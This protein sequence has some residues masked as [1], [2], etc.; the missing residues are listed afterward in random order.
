MGHGAHVFGGS[1]LVWSVQGVVT[2]NASARGLALSGVGGLPQAAAWAEAWEKLLH[3]AAETEALN[4]DR[5]DA[6]WSALGELR[7]AARVAAASPA[8]PATG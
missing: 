4:L 7:R 8:P 5:A 6:F 1:T 3:L 2:I